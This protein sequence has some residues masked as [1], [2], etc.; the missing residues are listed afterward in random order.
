MISDEPTRMKYFFRDQ[1]RM[2]NFFL[3]AAFLYSPRPRSAPT[4]TQV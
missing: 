4:R 2:C 1:V 3:R